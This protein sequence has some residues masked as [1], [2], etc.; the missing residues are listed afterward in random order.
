MATFPGLD[1][2]SNF[3]PIFTFLLSFSLIYG[4]MAKTKPFGEKKGIDSLVALSFSVLLLFS[5]KAVNIFSFIAPW[6]VI[7]VIVGFFTIFIFLIF[8]VNMDTIS[9]TLTQGEYSKT[10][11]G[12]IIAIVLILVVFAFSIEF[13]Q[14]VGPYLGGSDSTISEST[15]NSSTSQTTGSDS[16]VTGTGTATSDFKDNLGATLFH[17]KVLGMIIIFLIGSFSIR[18][19]AGKD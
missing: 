12:T 17:P 4:F 19:I 15:S 8:G 11:S 5:T 7:T 1:L 10:I 14:D 2:T 6:F 13:G 18:F 9:K 16:D 3:A